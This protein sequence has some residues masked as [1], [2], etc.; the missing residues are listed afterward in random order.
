MESTFPTKEIIEE[1]AA[2][3]AFCASH[4]GIDQQEH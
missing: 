2:Y 4:S 3:I 1:A